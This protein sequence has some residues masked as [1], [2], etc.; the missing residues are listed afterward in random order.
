MV[1][2]DIVF[3]DGKLQR[4]KKDEGGAGVLCYSYAKYGLLELLWFNSIMHIFIEIVG[5]GKQSSSR[6]EWHIVAL[7]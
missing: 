5:M 2:R 3:G 6:K 4:R 7:F 1:Q